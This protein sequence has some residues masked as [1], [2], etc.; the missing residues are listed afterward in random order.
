MAVQGSVSTAVPQTSPAP[1]K[2]L[3]TTV[4]KS[5]DSG[6]PSVSARPLF[7]RAGRGD[8]TRPPPCSSRPPPPPPSHFAPS[9]TPNTALPLTS[10]SPQKQAHSSQAYGSGHFKTNGFPPR[11]SFPG[12][13]ASPHAPTT[14]LT[15]N[16][17]RPHHRQSGA[18][19]WASR[20]HEPSPGQEGR[21]QGEP[22]S[23]LPRLLPHLALPSTAQRQ[24][25]MPYDARQ[26]LLSSLCCAAALAQ[27]GT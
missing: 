16:R 6:E 4:C 13:C 12:A 27:R 18:I 17:V 21:H 7:G 3:P 10:D 22:R 20:S 23:S 15:T 1:S 8:E 26:T 14:A 19:P 5:S 25:W 11:A 9:G 24:R 2:H